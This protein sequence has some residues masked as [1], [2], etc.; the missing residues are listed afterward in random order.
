MREKITCAKISKALSLL[1]ENRQMMKEPNS[2]ERHTHRP[3][4]T[5]LHA[6]KLCS[7]S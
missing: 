4:G 6:A 3:H 1:P 5:V 2:Q 7:Y